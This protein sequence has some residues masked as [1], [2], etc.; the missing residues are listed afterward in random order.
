MTEILNGYAM[1]LADAGRLDDAQRSL[2]EGLALSR[3]LKIDG[4]IAQALDY[5][6]ECSFYRGDFKT[7]RGL[8]EQALQFASRSKEP[9]KILVTKLHISKAMLKEGKPADAARAFKKLA[10]EADAVG[11]SYVSLESSLYLGE[12]L[13]EAKNYAGARQELERV[14]PKAEKLEMRSILAQDHYLLATMLRLSGH[15]TEA[16][17]HYRDALKYLEEIRTEAGGSV[18]QRSDLNTIYVDSTRWSQPINKQP[19]PE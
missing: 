10:L 9:E 8:Y 4:S 15:G 19:G 2:E 16:A 17:P 11:L 3:E 1:A 14:A 13:V 12:A 5:Q 18:L 7:A 6:G